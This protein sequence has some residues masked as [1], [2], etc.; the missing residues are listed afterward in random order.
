MT[1][2]FGSDPVYTYHTK[3]K[4]KG[5]RGV[6]FIINNVNFGNGKDRESSI[7]DAK[8]LRS[9][10][11]RLDYRTITRHDLSSVA[12]K[13]ELSKIANE[14]V[15]EDHDSFVC[16]ILSHGNERGIEGIGGRDDVISVP[17]L[18]EII[19]C[20]NCPKLFGKPKIFFIQ[21]CRGD[22]TPDPVVLDNTT[23]YTGDT[24]VADGRRRALPP[25]ADFMISFCTS[26]DN[27]ACRGLNTGAQ[28]IIK[29]CE[30]IDKYSSKLNLYELL[31]VV[32]REIV[33]LE[34]KV[35]IGQSDKV[36]HQMPELRSTLQ[37]KFK[38]EK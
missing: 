23:I 8:K 19:N 13:D 34:F 27:V 1:D 12:M 18:T 20:K 7:E 16:C 24:Q 22:N 38:F 5:E 4:G 10:F 29:L 26:Q 3:G 25:E 15:K 37:G 32:H 33:A 30:T 11:E 17:E 2:F 6:A 36:Y 28:Y 14:A 21:A 35:T 9:T 31:L